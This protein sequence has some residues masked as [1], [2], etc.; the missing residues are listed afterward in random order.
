MTAAALEREADRLLVE[1]G[2]K[3]PFV[4]KADLAGSADD[5]DVIMYAPHWVSRRVARRMGVRLK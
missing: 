3:E 1:S 4:T 2:Y 5:I